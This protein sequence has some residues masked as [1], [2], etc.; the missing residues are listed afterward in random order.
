MKDNVI[1]EKECADTQGSHSNFT[2]E[3]PVFPKRTLSNPTLYFL[4][5][6]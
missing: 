3:L 5:V 6:V 2:F 1:D 4:Y